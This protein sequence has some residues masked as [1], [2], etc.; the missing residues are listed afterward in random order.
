[1]F[2]TNYYIPLPYFISNHAVPPYSF[3][4]K[5]YNVP[6]LRINSP[7]FTIFGFELNILFLN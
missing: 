3:R 5:L 7:L 6:L 1:M 4:K 2:L